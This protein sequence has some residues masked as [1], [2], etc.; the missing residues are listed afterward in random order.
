M[1]FHFRNLIGETLYQKQKEIG[2]NILDNLTK[3]GKELVEN[4]AD[5][6]YVLQKAVLRDAQ[7]A[8]IDAGIKMAKKQ[9]E[10]N[11]D[12]LVEKIRS[13]KIIGPILASVVNKYREEIIN[14]I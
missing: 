9:L 2:Q 4:I 5:D 1:G 6:V 3:K 12:K 11:F 13:I 10:R 7:N 14:L 8:A